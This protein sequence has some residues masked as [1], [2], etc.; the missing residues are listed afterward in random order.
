MRTWPSVCYLK[1]KISILPESFVEL[2]QKLV[3]FGYTLKCNN[4][5]M[6]LKVK[7]LNFGQNSI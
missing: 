2:E 4:M 7:I 3:F 6:K 5:K 1:V